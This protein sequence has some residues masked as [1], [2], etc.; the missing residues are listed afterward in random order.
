MSSPEI[1][2][3]GERHDRKSPEYRGGERPASR[4]HE[5]HSPESA[6]REIE[7]ARKEALGKALE[8]KQYNT[9]EQSE[10]GPAEPMVASSAKL[11]QSFNKTI[12]RVQAGLPL[13]QRIFSKVIHNPVI[14]KTSD[15]VGSTVARPDAVLSGSLTAFVL[16][17]AL[18]FTARYFGFAL[19]G[20]ETIATFIIGW[21]LGLLFDLL[22]GMFRGQR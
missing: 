18:Y 4:E 21:L 5:Q 12:G 19:S 10:A 13:P 15:I 22:K 17:A 1:H 6:Q 11:K 20:S 3:G 2:G 9:H 14:E 8:E 16:T 7:S